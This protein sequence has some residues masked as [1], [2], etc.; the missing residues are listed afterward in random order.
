MENNPCKDV[1]DFYGAIWPQLVSKIGAAVDGEPEKIVEL[2]NA[3]FDILQLRLGSE[4]RQEG[5][6]PELAPTS[7]DR[8]LSRSKLKR[9]RYPCHECKK[10]RQKVRRSLLWTEMDM[11]THL[12][13]SVYDPQWHRKPARDAPGRSYSVA[14]PQAC[15]PAARNLLFPTLFGAQTL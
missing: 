10:S 15:A 1:L 13:G 6:D 5:Y 11:V 14:K 9:N 3:P 8:A 12:C 2:Q 7:V 4:Q